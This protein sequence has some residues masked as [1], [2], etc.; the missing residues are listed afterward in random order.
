MLLQGLRRRR[1][2]SWWIISFALF[3]AFDGDVLNADL[4]SIS[5]QM[6][7]HPPWR[8]IHHDGT[9]KQIPSPP[10]VVIHVNA[11]VLPAISSWCSAPSNVICLSRFC[12]FLLYTFPEVEKIFFWRLLY[13]GLCLYVA[14]ITDSTQNY[15]TQHTRPSRRFK[16]LKLK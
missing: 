9:I 11:F 14:I 1:H 6:T 12:F 4:S 15:Y 16:N 13:F 7:G 8:N 5:E 2:M 3:I 10:S